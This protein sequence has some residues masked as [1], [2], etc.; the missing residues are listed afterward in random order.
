MD[1]RRNIIFIGL[2]VVSYMLILAWNEDYGQVAFYNGTIEELYSKID[3]II[4][5]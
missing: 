4:K 5:R 1:V 3:E 2:A